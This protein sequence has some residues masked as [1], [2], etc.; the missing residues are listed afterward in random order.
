MA[1]PLTIIS[2]AIDDI[3]LFLARLECIEVQPLPKEHEVASRPQ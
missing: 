1:E 3:P 2:E